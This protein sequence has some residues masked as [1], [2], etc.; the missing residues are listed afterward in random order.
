MSP[1]FALLTVLA[2]NPSFRWRI[3]IEHIVTHYTHVFRSLPQKF[4]WR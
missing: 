2:L 4:E 1:V 3:S